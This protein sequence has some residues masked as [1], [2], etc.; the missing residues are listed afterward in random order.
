MG[1]D[2]AVDGAWHYETREHELYV[3]GPKIELHLSWAQITG[4]GANTAGKVLV[5]TDR[6]LYFPIERGGEQHE[7]FVA[8]LD[9]HLGEKWHGDGLGDIRLRKRLGYATWWVCPAAIL[10]AMLIGAVLIGALGIFGFVA[11]LVE[12]YFWVLMIL[13]LVYIVA[14]WMKKIRS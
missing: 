6:L 7:R 5:A 13:G 2:F 9:A 14:V 3:R 4:A 10:F 1:Y 8:D 12:D 11:G